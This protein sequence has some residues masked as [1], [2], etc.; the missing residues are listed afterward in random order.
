MSQFSMNLEEKII[1]R[2]QKKSCL[3]IDLDGV[4]YQGKQPILG[5]VDALA[6]FRTAGYKIAFLTNNSA[7][8]SF[9]ILEKLWSFGIDCN[10]QHLMTA[11][12]ASATL[13]KEQNLDAD[14]GVFVIGTEGLKQTLT[15]EGIGCVEPEMCGAVLAGLDP[16]FNYFAI[17]QGLTA[18]NRGVPFIICNRDANF[19]GDGGNLL[20]GCG[21][22][23]GAL[24]AT[25][26]RKAT[27]EIG[28]PNTI[29]LDLLMKQLQVRPADCLVIGD[30][31][32]YDILMANRANIASV[33]IS[34]Q[35]DG[36]RGESF[37]KPDLRVTS[38]IELA[39][40]LENS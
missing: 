27:L 22:M 9:S 33:W 3:L 21:A 17:S 7:S 1:G 31:L 39:N 18:L 29:M 19:P 5:A 4:V 30:M 8:H 13:I 34:D 36:L 10:S 12:Q 16:N 6:K 2:I 23:A 15:S 14:R 24:E 40:L 38:L 37:A 25:S 32:D 35:K 11:A 20:P 26:G 28:K